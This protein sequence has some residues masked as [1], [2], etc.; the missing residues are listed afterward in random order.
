VLQVKIEEEEGE[1]KKKKFEKT[2]SLR[3]AS[4]HGASAEKG[5]R[6]KKR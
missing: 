5:E 3:K 4:E 6:E 2:P 1:K